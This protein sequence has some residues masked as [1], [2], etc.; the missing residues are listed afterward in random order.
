MSHAIDGADKVRRL[1]FYSTAKSAENNKEVQDS[2]QFVWTLMVDRPRLLLRRQQVISGRAKLNELPHGARWGDYLIKKIPFNTVFREYHSLLRPKVTFTPCFMK[3]NRIGAGGQDPRQ[4]E[5]LKM[6]VRPF[7]SDETGS[8]TP[9]LRAASGTDD[10]RPKLSPAT[11]SRMSVQGMSMS[12]GVQTGQRQS[13]IPLNRR[14]PQSSLRSNEERVSSIQ[15]STPN[16][17]PGR[18][19]NSNKATIS[20]QPARDAHVNGEHRQYNPAA[21]PEYHRRVHSS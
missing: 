5:M 6:S 19:R 3:E 12:N 9:S 15:S 17:S 7:V 8:V 10:Q 16:R 14:P 4:M 18:E 1:R 20:T 2:S 13:E 21:P 11:G